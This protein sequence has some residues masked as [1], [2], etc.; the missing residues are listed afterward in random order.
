MLNIPQRQ[1]TL[2]SIALIAG[3]IIFIIYEF[4]IVDIG[5]IRLLIFFYGL[6]IPFF[7]LS[8]DLIID[9]KDSNVFKTWA[10]LAFALVIIFILLRSDEN[11]LIRNKG[12]GD[13]KIRDWISDNSAATLKCL[14]SFLVIYWI[15]NSILIKT[16]GKYIVSTYKLSKWYNTAANRKVNGIDVVINLTLYTTIIL[17]AILKP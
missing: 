14:P 15:I 9:L 11:L 8:S 5:I 3:L 10:A 16:Q 17:A 4:H 12:I 1:K 6:G 7:I 2:L 13:L